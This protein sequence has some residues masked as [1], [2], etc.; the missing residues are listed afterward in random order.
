[1]S[2]INVTPIIDITEL[3]ASDNVNEGDVIL[4]EEGIYFQTVNVLKN[5]IRIV[6]KGPGVIFDG[7]ST[8]LTAFTLPE[9]SGVVI[10]GI[11]IRYYRGDGIL[12][13]F[14]SGNRII[15]NTINNMIEH[16]VEVI[17]SSSNLIWK[18]EISNCYDGVL[19]I[20]GSTNNWVIENVARECYGDGYEAFLDPDSNNAFISNTAIGNRNNGLEIYGGNNLLLDNVLIDNG[21]G[22][23][24]NQGNSSI[25][26]GNMIKGTKEGTYV[27][28]DSYFNHFVSENHIVCNRREGIENNG[29]FNM[30]VNNEISNNGDTGILLVETSILNLVMDNKL[31]CNIPQNIEDRGID[32]YLINN[33]EKP[34]EPCKSPTD[35]CVERKDGEDN[36]TD[37][38]KEGA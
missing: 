21:Q 38:S 36:T 26:I 14:G 2:V 16:G 23:I 7:R 31:V 1:M 27:I 4:L 24:I 20:S 33:M 34:C 32:N 17:S 18:N 19:L 9:V 30:I 5:N 22:V 29:Q 11:N 12:I 8:L 10:E 28:F 25:A 6:A 15:N 3:I 37:G 13:E 35:V